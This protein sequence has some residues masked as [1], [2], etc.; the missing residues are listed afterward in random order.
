VCCPS[1]LEFSDSLV[2]ISH[3]QTSYSSSLIA[4]GTAGY[5]SNSVKS[6]NNTNTVC[7]LALTALGLWPDNGSLKKKKEVLK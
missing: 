1:I 3:T 5:Q 2:G 7:I 6:A 4:T